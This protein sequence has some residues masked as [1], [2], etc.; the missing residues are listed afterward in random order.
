MDD[1]ER[2]RQDLTNF[3]DALQSVLISI[4]NLYEVTDR[5]VE[6]EQVQDRLQDGRSTLQLMAPNLVDNRHRENVNGLIDLLNMIISSISE[7]LHR[8]DIENEDHSTAFMCQTV[9]SDRVGRPSIAVDEEQITFLRSLHFS[10]RKIAGLLGVSE[11][12][13]RRRR[14]EYTEGNENNWSAITGINC[15]SF[16]PFGRVVITNLFLPINRV[17]LAS[18]GLVEILV[19]C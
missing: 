3:F 5:E 18:E 6:L 11:S 19:R 17:T 7:H 4:Q 10:W 9:H 2:N 1:R 8:S 15:W 14:K 13:L 16:A 12:T